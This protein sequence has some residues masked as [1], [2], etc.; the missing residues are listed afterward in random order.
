MLPI[1]IS[2]LFGGITGTAIQK[3]TSYCECYRS[4]FDGKYCQS[5]K[6]TGTQGTCEG[7]K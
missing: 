5:I 1:L 4:D 2:I 6:G 3:Q 7:K